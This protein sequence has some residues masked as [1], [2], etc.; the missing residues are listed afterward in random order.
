MT[1]ASTVVH[2][3]HTVPLIEPDR[4]VA[5]ILE[6]T[7]AIPSMKWYP[8]YE[9]DCSKIA[10]YEYGTHEPDTN[11]YQVECAFIC[12]PSQDGRFG[13]GPQ[14]EDDRQFYYAKRL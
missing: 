10:R 13:R 14:S 9:M 12:Y 5:A 3:R 4:A 11:Q 1:K 7:T 8:I 2:L 6:Q